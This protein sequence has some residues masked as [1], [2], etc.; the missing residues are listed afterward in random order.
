MSTAASAF[1]KTA[2]INPN[3][4]RDSKRANFKG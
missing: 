1:G 4:Q 2:K 3:A